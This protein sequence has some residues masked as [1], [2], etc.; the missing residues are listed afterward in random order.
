MEDEYVDERQAQRII[1]IFKQGKAYI[2]VSPE[3]NHDVHYRVFNNFRKTEEFDTLSEKI[4]QMIL[5]RIEKHKFYMAQ[6]KA[7]AAPQPQVG[8]QG[9]AV[10]TE[11]KIPDAVLEEAIR[12][13]LGAGAMA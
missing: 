10:G 2:E 1:D 7:A 5:K 3:D 11:Q 12:Q 9:P 13:E 6:A 4:K 8:P